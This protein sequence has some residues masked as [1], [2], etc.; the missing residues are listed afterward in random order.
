MRTKFRADNIEVY[1]GERENSVNNFSQ[2][3]T[4]LKRTPYHRWIRREVGSVKFG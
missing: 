1:W 3:V 4:A 2:L